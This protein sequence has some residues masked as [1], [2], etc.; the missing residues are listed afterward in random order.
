MLLRSLRLGLQED[1]ARNSSEDMKGDVTLPSS[2]LTLSP[3]LLFSF[4]PPYLPPKPKV[5]PP[6]ATFDEAIALTGQGTS[7]QWRVVI[8]SGLCVLSAICETVGVAYFLP[9]ARC[10]LALTVA[11]K[12]LLGG[13]ASAGMTLGSFSWGV[14]ADSWGRKPVLLTSLFL[15]A[16]MGTLSSL[17]PHL[18]VLLI[19]RLLSGVCAAGAAAV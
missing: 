18:Y 9:Y 6:A 14:L 1:A 3:S 8:A 16:I 13:A 17:A 12:T 2:F 10:D 5:L 11:E 15:V 4:A 7:C 19:F